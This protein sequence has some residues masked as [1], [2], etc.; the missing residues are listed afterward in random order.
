MMVFGVIEIVVLLVGCAY[1]DAKIRRCSVISELS[2]QL[3][4]WCE[5]AEDIYEYARRASFI[6][7][8]DIKKA[9]KLSGPKT[10][11]DILKDYHPI[12]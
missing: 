9:I 8:W 11:E 5:K 2:K 1:Y 3:Y 4:A 6:L 12:Y 10:L 7:D